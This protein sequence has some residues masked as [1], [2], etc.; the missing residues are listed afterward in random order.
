YFRNQ[1]NHLITP[2]IPQIPFY[3]QLHHHQIS[4][5]QIKPI[6]PKPIILSPP[7]NSLYQ[8][9]SFT[10]D[11]HIYN[12]PIPVLAISYPIQLTTKL[13]RPKLQP[14]NEPQYRK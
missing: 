1:Y 14:P 4:I 6:N 12:L 9:P 3:I 10:I 8:Q 5:H 11:P 7:P 2:P 13:L